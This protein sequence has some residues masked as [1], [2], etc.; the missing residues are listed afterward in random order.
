[1]DSAHTVRLKCP[2]CGQPGLA[3]WAHPENGRAGARRLIALTQGFTAVGGGNRREPE[4]RC[5]K[6]DEVPPGAGALTLA[7]A[8]D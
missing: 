7:L 6:C 8:A 3:H 4:V 5:V 1:M 2:T